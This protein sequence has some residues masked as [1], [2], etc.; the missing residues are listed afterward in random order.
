[1]F[2]YHD[3]NLRTGAN[4]SETVLTPSNVN[5]SSFGKLFS[6]PLDGIAYAAPLYVENVSIPAAG[7]HN[8][9]YVATEHDSVYAFD[10]D[11]R[12]TTPLWKDSFID[13][14]NGITTVPADDTGECCDI[15]PEIGIT[16]TPVIDH[17]T[18][19]LYV[20]A[21][22][23]EVVGGNTNY[24]IRLHALDLSTGAE[25]FGGPVVDSGERARNRRRLVRRRPA[26]PAT[27]R[28]P[29]HGA[30]SA[31][32]RSSTSPSR[33][34]ATS[35]RTTAGSS[36]TTPRRSSG[37][38]PSAFHRTRTVRACGWVAT[39]SQAMQPAV[40]ISSP[41]T[42]RSTGAPTGV[43]ATSG[44]RRAESSPTP[45]LLSTRPRSTRRTT[46]SAR[47]E[48]CS[49]PTRRALIRTRW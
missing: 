11:G 32:R 39:D 10:A 13:P 38:S 25:K 43:T 45:S 15:A 6:R 27:P 46:I 36:A 33:V 21:A 41:A 5:S 42:D 19:T 9:V 24:V 14:A 16:G 2:T 26:V 22:T 12:S 31:Q 20:V 37:R 47:A 40:C 49:F 23:K 18:N 28:E 3:D 30:A 8:V 29:A 34:T 4:L 7:A 17:A 1:M 44:C 35:S 48:R